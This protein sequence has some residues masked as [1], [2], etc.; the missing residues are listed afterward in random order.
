MG[1]IHRYLSVIRADS[2]DKPRV[3]YSEW[4]PN[5]DYYELNVEIDSW[6]KRL[7]VTETRMDQIMEA[8]HEIRECL[9]SQA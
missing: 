7:A 8:Y 2:D 5:E 4:Q 3:C 9:R 1:A 6:Y